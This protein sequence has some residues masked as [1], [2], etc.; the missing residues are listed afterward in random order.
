MLLCP[1]L[2]LGA[3]S[4]IILHQYKKEQKKNPRA[5]GKRLDPGIIRGTAPRRRLT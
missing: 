3:Y 2:N 5:N 4:I 1:K